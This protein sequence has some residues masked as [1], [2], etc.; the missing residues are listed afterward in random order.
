MPPRFR[1]GPA[2]AALAGEAVLASCALSGQPV[3]VGRAAYSEHC[4]SCHGTRARGDGQMAVFV[5]TGV[6]DLR[7]LSQ[8]NGGEFPAQR[9]YQTID[10]R[11]ELA[12]HGS[13]EMP[14]WGI[15]FQDL[16]RDA[17]Q[18]QSVRDKILDVVSYLKTLQVEDEN[19]GD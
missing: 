7:G 4:S 12:S 18:E 17:D 19:G 10:G 11:Q 14:V 3:S 6:P 9:V 5:A 2:L 16:G 13:R 1:F 8:R 15:G